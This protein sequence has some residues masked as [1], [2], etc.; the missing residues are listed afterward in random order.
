MSKTSLKDLVEKELPAEL[1]EYVPNR[2]DVVGDIAIVSIP[3]ALRNYSEMIATKIVS[4]RSSIQTVLNKVSRVKGDHRVSDFEI[5]LGDSTVT[6]HG[7]FKHRYRL[8]L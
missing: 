4:M 2:F 7:E 1:I 8:D 6:T 5:L 3:P